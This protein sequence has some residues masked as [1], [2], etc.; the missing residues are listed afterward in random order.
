VSIL[1]FRVDE[2]L[3]HGQVVLGWGSHLRA[4]RYVVVDDEIALA[5]WEQELYR[6]ALPVG[7]QS[8]SAEFA[9]CETAAQRLGEWEEDSTPTVL[10]TRH[11]ETMLALARGGAMKGRKVNLGG[12]HYAPGRKELLPYLHVEEADVERI[13]WLDQAGVAVE[14]QD[15]PSAPVLRADVLLRKGRRMWS[16]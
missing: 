10:L 1:L 4:Q 8:V 14:A 16:G 5:E 12:L 3:I 15:L 13:G 2:R 6:L 11:L 7:P 9:S